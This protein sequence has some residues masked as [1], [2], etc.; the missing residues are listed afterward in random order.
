ML[1]VAWA[2]PR[3]S[4]ASDHNRANCAK[5][6]PYKPKRDVRPMPNTIAANPIWRQQS[7]TPSVLVAVT[8]QRTYQ[9]RTMSPCCV[10]HVCIAI[11][12]ATPALML[13]V[14]PNCAIDTVIA[15][16]ARASS[17]IPGPS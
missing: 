1:A 17:V 13:R 14:E 2:W 8:R 6:S 15:A 11:P 3:S 12:A 10:I 7:R 4:S 16:P 5:T 9:A